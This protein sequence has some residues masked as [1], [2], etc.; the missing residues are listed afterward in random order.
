MYL[1][2]THN[3]QGTDR[4]VMS[5][6]SINFSHI[7]TGVQM[8]AGAM[9]R[10]RNLF[11]RWNKYTRPEGR[12]TYPC[13]HTHTSAIHKEI[14]LTRTYTALSQRPSNKGHQRNTASSSLI[15]KYV[16][17]LYCRL[18]QAPIGLPAEGH[19]CSTLVYAARI[20]RG[21]MLLLRLLLLRLPRGY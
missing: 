15:S 14:A 5:Q 8:A 2:N 3:I 21:R 6:P 13:K 12:P 1:Q 20:C 19:K 18:A 10:L 11:I 17:E 16:Q 7:I 4:H 9:N